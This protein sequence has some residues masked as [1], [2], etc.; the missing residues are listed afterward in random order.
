M[1]ILVWKLVVWICSLTMEGAVADSV[2]MD[3]QDTLPLDIHEA[4]T[5]PEAPSS[6]SPEVPSQKRREQF[7]RLRKKT[8]PEE[9][10]LQTPVPKSN[11]AKDVNAST[12]IKQKE[13]TELKRETV[14]NKAWTWAEA[15]GG[16]I[17]VWT[18][19]ILKLRYDVAVFQF[20][21]GAFGVD[22][23]IYAAT[24]WCARPRLTNPMSQDKISWTWS[25]TNLMEEVVVEGKVGEKDEEEVNPKLKR[26]KQ[27]LMMGMVVGERNKDERN[28]KTMCS[29]L[30]RILMILTG[31]KRVGYWGMAIRMRSGHLM[32]MEARDTIGISMRG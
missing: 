14:G 27:R 28:L 9:V 25:R 19:C 7:Q 10:N 30:M 15:M 2:A 3:N 1:L 6:V 23:E 32:A 16:I 22:M 17:F 13:K 11:P 8:H 21:F 24:S 5:P 31:M 29:G 18:K 20:S 26:R 12:N 4:A